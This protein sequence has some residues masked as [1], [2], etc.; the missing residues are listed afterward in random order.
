MGSPLE[1][2]N[3]QDQVF[4][5]RITKMSLKNTG[6]WNGLMRQKTEI[7]MGKFIILFFQISKF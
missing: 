5:E 2:D 1:I 3:L 7:I 4:G 6:L